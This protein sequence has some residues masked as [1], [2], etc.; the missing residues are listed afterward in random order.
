VALTNRGHLREKAEMFIIRK[1]D[2]L[3]HKIP[4]EAYIGEV[5]LEVM[6]LA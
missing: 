5:S 1:R 2:G 6:S 4:V 3:S